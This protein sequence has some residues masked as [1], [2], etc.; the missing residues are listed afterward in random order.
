MQDKYYELEVIPS[1]NIELFCDFI[2]TLFPEAI[3][4]TENS[5][6]VRSEESLE[7]IEWGVKEFAQKLSSSLKK[8]VYVKTVLIEKNS[9]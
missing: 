1:S 5:L 7:L 4:E 9:E 6:V 2:L 3:E 8:E